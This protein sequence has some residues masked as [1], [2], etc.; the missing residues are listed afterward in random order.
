[1]GTKKC[2]EWGFGYGESEYEL[3]FGVA[4]RNEEF[5]PSD[6]VL[7]ENIALSY[8]DNRCVASCA[9]KTPKHKIKKNFRADL[10]LIMTRVSNE[11]TYLWDVREVGPARSVDIQTAVRAH[12]V[13]LKIAAGV[14]QC[15]GH[16]YAKIIVPTPPAC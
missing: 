13:A 16:L 8:T 2:V 3:S 12:I 10:T 5:S 6:P 15:V 9:L 14:V 4:P 1:M 11:R 7:C